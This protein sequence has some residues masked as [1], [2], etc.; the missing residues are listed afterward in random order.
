MVLYDVTPPNRPIIGVYLK[1]QLAKKPQS[2]SFLLLL[3]SLWSLVS[4]RAQQA[5]THSL[6]RKVFFHHKRTGC[7]DIPPTGSA[8][9]AYGASAMEMV[10]ESKTSL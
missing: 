7:D 9:M 3:R 5:H 10:S 4:M 2:R 8:P 6:R 1:M